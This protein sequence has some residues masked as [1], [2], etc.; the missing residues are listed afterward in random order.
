LEAAN[1]EFGISDLE[2]ANLE[3]GI[4]DLGAANLEFGISDLGVLFITFLLILFESFIIYNLI[5]ISLR[6]SNHFVFTKSKNTIRH[7]G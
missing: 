5:I 7:G 4:S 3:F 6:I 1:L 2:A